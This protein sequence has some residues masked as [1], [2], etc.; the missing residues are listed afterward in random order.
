M[1]KVGE[2]VN[3]FSRFTLMGQSTHAVICDRCDTID[4]NFNSRE[5]VNLETY[6]ADL[7]VC[8]SRERKRHQVRVQQT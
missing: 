3:G 6:P 7:H 2:P 8:V 5:A 1:K 4:A